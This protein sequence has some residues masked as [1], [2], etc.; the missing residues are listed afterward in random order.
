[1]LSSYVLILHYILSA[2][3]RVTCVVDRTNTSFLQIR[4]RAA[5]QRVG[6]GKEAVLIKTPYSLASPVL[7]ARS[8]VVSACRSV[9]RIVY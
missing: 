5:A 2:S 8:G 6:K 4:S 9:V 1:M 7:G 3:H